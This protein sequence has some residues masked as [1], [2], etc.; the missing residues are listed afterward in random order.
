MTITIY[1]ELEQ[2]TP[3]W[4]QARCGLL[5]ASTMNLILTPTCKTANNDK[6]RAH[7]YEIAA[8]RITQYVEP[9]FM[10]ND[11]MRGHVD[12]IEARQLYAERYAPVRQ[13]G[14]MTNDR[15]GFTLGYSPDGLVYDDGLIECKSRRQKYQFR[16]IAE[17]EVP[18]EYWLQ[19][20]TALLVSEREYVDFISFCGGMPM[21]VH[22]VM[23]D[24]T[25]QAAILTAAETFYDNVN[26]LIAQYKKN[27]ATFKFI[28]TVRRIE[29]EEI[30]L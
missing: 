11:M 24:A 17:N 9:V 7:V 18:E 12:E 15:W 8:Q 22:R 16:T 20:Q 29:S 30:L 25:I 27:C 28:E 23:A 4:L 3:E 19:L 1:D 2:G 21:F 5:T 26:K 14:F 10:T 13:V 6:S